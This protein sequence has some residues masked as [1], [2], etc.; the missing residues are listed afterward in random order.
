[1]G[2]LDQLKLL[3]ANKRAERGSSR[4]GVEKHGDISQTRNGSPDAIDR[5]AGVAPGPR[6][7][8]SKGGR[9][10]AK[11]AA[12]ALMQTQP[13]KAAGMSRATYYRRKAEGAL[14]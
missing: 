1:M 4:G 12:K 13:W 10:L 5:I 2:K 14:P 11:D 7:T 8:K 6:G 3:G 9:P